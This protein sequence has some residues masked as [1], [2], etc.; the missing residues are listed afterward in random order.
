MIPDS[1]NKDDVTSYFF[2][3]LAESKFGEWLKT[4]SWFVKKNK[5]ILNEI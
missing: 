2:D 3:T 4:A 5:L 1:F